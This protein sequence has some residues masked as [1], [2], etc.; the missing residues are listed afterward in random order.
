[1]SALID[2]YLTH[3][4]VER[5]LAANSVESYARDLALLGAFA[6]GRAAPLDGLARA[7]LEAL[8]RDLMSEG[9]SPRSVARAVACFRGFY[10]F[11]VI[12]GRI[13]AS[14]AD[15]LPRRS[16]PTT[17]AGDLPIASASA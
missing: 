13:K 2:S 11:P 9:R 12:D 7:D 6:A 4:T 16:L 5:R 15:D 17:T 8:V 1:M 3:L 10:R 14:P